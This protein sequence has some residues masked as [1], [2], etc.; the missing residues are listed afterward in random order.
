MSFR[1]DIGSGKFRVAVLNDYSMEQALKLVSQGQYPSQHTWGA[2]L[3]GKLG[4]KVIV[5]KFRGAGL[6]ASFKTQIEVYLHQRDID[7]VYSACQSETWLLARL[8]YYGLFRCPIVAVIHHPIKGRLRGGRSFVK[9]HDR[10]LFLSRLSRESI[11]HDWP[12][13]A[14]KSVVIEW[15]VDI[16]FYDQQNILP[17]P[18]G[19]NYFVSAGKANRDHQTLA[20]C[21][22]LVQHKTL[23]V[24]S[25]D[26]RPSSYDPDWVSVVGDRS[27]HALSYVQLTAV[28]RSARVI[29]IP[30]AHVV[31]LAGLTSL[32]DA[33]ACGR[34]VIM[35]RNALIDVD[36]ESL[37]FGIW[38]SAGDR[39]SLGNAMRL[40]AGDDEL[41]QVMG[42]KARAYAERH[43]CYDNFAKQALMYCADAIE[44]VP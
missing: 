23:I 12:D 39:D 27:G 35:T 9:G 34:P 8:R 44:C 4:A 10:L 21:A 29:V 40:L 5:P 37:G 13:M 17:H 31:G 43:Y 38:V 42:K 24:C 32:L 2:S 28:Y 18:H 15:G 33:I 14:E 41:V 20:D 6:W 19:E 22:G 1:S 11:A 26:T 36:I 30:L 16:A 3:F 25:D 7:V